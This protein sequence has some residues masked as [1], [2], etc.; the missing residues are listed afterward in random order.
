[1]SAGSTTA[2]RW[3]RSIA[4]VESQVASAVRGEA[5]GD[6]A[7]SIFVTGGHVN[8]RVPGR[9]RIGSAGDGPSFAYAWFHD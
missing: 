7:M 9:S 1:M 5:G 4:K 8:L 3:R 2:R 6:F